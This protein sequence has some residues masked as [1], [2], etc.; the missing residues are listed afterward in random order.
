MN[1]LNTIKELKFMIF[2]SYYD[3]KFHLMK[4]FLGETICFRYDWKDVDIFRKLLEYSEVTRVCMM[5]IK[6]I[7]QKMNSFIRDFF[8]QAL[9]SL[10][11]CGS[12]VDLLYLMVIDFM[13]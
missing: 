13:L 8:D 11:V 1:A 7:E 5:S 4:F 2:R 3:I 9:F 12:V 10:M 6:E